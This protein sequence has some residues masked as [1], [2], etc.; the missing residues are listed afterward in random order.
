ME[1]Q[2]G[3]FFKMSPNK[4]DLRLWDFLLKCR[5][6]TTDTLIKCQEKKKKI[7]GGQEVNRLIKARANRKR[8]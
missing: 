3:P 7:E 6:S 1:I 8:V 4:L 5:F 2:S